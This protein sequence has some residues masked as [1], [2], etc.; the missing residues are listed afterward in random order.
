MRL[1]RLRVGS[2][3]DQKRRTGVP[4]VMHTKVLD[5]RTLERR[6]PVVCAERLSPQWPA[7]RFGEDECFGLSLDVMGEVFGETVPEKAW[8]DDGPSLVGLGWPE[9][10]AS[11]DLRE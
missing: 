6:L 11:S 8:E 3:G 7:S 1:H 9:V 4:Q 10:E 2:G 5:S